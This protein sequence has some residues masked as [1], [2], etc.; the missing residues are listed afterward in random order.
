MVTRRD[1]TIEE[2]TAKIDEL[3]EIIRKRDEDSINHEMEKDL[4][5]TQSYVESYD[6]LA[7]PSQVNIEQSVSQG[8]YHLNSD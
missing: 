6:H 4:L 2:L 5:N 8:E 3:E 7:Y 1:K